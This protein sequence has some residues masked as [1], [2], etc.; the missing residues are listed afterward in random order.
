MNHLGKTIASFRKKWGIDQKDLAKAI[1]VS[2]AYISIVESGKRKPNMKLLEKIAAYF[3]VPIYGLLHEAAKDA[4][5]YKNKKVKETLKTVDPI[6]QTLMG[7]LVSAA[8]EKPNNTQPIS[9]KAPK[10]K[11]N[12]RKKA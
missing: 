11:S 2:T 5:A 12:V 7:A 6:I 10:T 4:G 8:S 1:G 9:Q 3:E